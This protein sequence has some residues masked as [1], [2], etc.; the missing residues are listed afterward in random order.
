MSYDRPM[1]GHLQSSILAGLNSWLRSELYP[2]KTTHFLQLFTAYRNKAMVQSSRGME[3]AVFVSL[4]DFSLVGKQRD[5]K[6]KR[7]FSDAQ[8]GVRL[9]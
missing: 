3:L 2:E 9:H 1:A 7:R 5:R 4:K 6:I 8:M